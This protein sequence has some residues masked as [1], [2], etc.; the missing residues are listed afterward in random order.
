MC[1]CDPGGPVREECP[2]R[3][4]SGEVKAL[5]FS[6]SGGMLA[7]GGHDRTVKVWDVALR[8]LC[9]TIDAG[10]MVHSIAWSLDWEPDRRLA[11]GMVLSPSLGAGSQAG[12]LEP[13]L[14]KMVLDFT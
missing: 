1:Q 13:G 11:F 9:H 2:V 6:P 14:V 3:G 4:H 5:A 12:E 7:S 8:E 10:A